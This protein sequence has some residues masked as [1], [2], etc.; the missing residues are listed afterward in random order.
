MLEGIFICIDVTA[1]FVQPLKFLSILQERE[2]KESNV[3]KSHLVINSTEKKKKTKVYLKVLLK[4]KSCNP[5][6]LNLLQVCYK[7]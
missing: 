5:C 4:A 1:W 7:V 2:A 6:N 3:T